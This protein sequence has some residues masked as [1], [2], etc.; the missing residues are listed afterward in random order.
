MDTGTTSTIYFV[1]NVVAPIDGN[2][3]Y[4]LGNSSDST[5]ETNTPG[6]ASKLTIKTFFDSSL[7]QPTSSTVNKSGAKLYV[8]ILL[9]DEYGNAVVNN[10]NYQLQI[11]LAGQGSFSA[12]SVYIAKNAFDTWGSF[13]P[14]LWYP[15]TTVGS[16]SISATS[17][18][19]TS[20]KSLTVVSATP[21]LFANTANS[22]SLSSGSTFYVNS[23]TVV[24]SGNASVSEGYPDTAEMMSVCYT[25]ATSNGCGSISAAN[26]IAP[27]NIQLVLSSGLNTVSF[28]ATDSIGNT[29]TSASFTILVDTGKPVAGFTTVKNANL[30]NGAAVIAWVYDLEG[31]L[32]A[33]SVVVHANGTA[34]PASQVVVTGTN[35]LGHNTTYTVTVSGLT[36]GK[37]NL[38]LDASSLAGN[39]A[40]TVYTT[41]NVKLSFAVSVVVS[42]TPT[43][44]TI[45][46]YTGISATYT[47]DWS[48][49]QNVIVFAVWKNSAGQTVAVSTGGLN[50]AVGATGT[51]FAPLFSP[52]PSGTYTVNIF[53]ITT[54]NQPVSITTTISV[55]V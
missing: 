5:S 4:M 47:N 44:T 36:S 29:A 23:G 35:N 40:T 24:V 43:K 32:K 21:T 10:L 46:G 53:V 22:A 50:L 12:T 15:P 39:A 38:A 9:A 8:N 52:L 26:V 41:V 17:S 1:A 33:S 37:W 2:P 16:I 48:A 34:V 27:W 49:S 11:A 54:S 42:G 19:G 30:T 3:T 14:I 28:N 20:T 18:L 45:G 51:A 55:T 25:R 31:D 13:G 7:T 6:P